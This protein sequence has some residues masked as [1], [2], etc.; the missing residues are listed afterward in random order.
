MI[1]NRDGKFWNFDITIIVKQNI[2]IIKIIVIIVLSIFA[3][4]IVY[5][6]INLYLIITNLVMTKSDYDDIIQLLP[7]TIIVCSKN[8]TILIIINKNITVNR[9]TS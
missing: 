7:L 1:Q 3:L 2:T 4:K 9:Q 5:T 6:C 8:H